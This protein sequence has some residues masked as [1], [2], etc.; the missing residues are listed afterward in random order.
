MIKYMRIYLRHI[1]LTIHPPARLVAIHM[2][3]KNRRYEEAKYILRSYKYDG[4]YRTPSILF[5]EIIG[6][7]GAGFE[8]IIEIIDDD[9][10][11]NDDTKRFLKNYIIFIAREGKYKDSEVGKSPPFPLKRANVER[12]IQIIFHHGYYY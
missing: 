11:L 12:Y 3:I 2:A 9:T 1:I 6:S 8:K 7:N 5:H 10:Y 4:I